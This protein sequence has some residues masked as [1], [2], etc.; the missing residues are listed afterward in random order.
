[1]TGSV[2]VRGAKDFQTRLPH[3]FCLLIILMEENMVQVV[4]FDQTK[5]IDPNLLHAAAMALNTQVTRDLPMYWS[6]ISANVSVAPSLSS[7]PTGS[8]AGISC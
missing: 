5:K 8:M 6:G 1:M 4:I 3:I 7:L 2:S